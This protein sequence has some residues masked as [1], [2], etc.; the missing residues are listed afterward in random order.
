[1]YTLGQ[2]HD[3]LS[4]GVPATSPPAFQD[5]TAA[6]GPTMH[7]LKELYD[8]I[9]AQLDQCDAGPEDIAPGK[10]YF[11]TNP[12]GWGVRT[13][14]TPIPTCVPTATPT[15]T[16][17]WYAQYGPA[18][19]GDVVQ[20][21]SMYVASKQDGTGSTQLPWQEG[22]DWAD[23]L[24]WLGK[25]DWRLPTGNVGGELSTICSAKD[26]APGFTYV[27]NGFYWSSTPAPGDYV[28]EVSFGDCF[29][30]WNEQKSES[31]RVRAVRNAE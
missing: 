21:G 27:H 12:C 26:S 6:P 9:K 17:D 18:G 29:V 4:T 13:G 16:P 3:Y 11:S 19:T 1:M 30:F 7:S 31:L 14:G 5:P 20:I 8:D 28:W 23:G 24:S 25:D 2:I 10:K 15:P 22:M